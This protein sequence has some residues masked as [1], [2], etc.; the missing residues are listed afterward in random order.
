[1]GKITS[2]I[3]LKHTQ[4][5]RDSGEALEMLLANEQFRQFSL[6]LQCSGDRVRGLTEIAFLESM[7]TTWCCSWKMRGSLLRNRK[8]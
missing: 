7:V 6:P 8:T 2:V 5:T 1:M 4:S 3:V